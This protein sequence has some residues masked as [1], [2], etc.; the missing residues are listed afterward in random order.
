M[1]QRFRLNIA[2]WR[3][4]P[5]FLL[6]AGVALLL[7]AN[8]VAAAFA[9]EPWGA[10][11]EDLERQAAALRQQI[12]QQRTTLDRTKAILKKVEV[13]RGESDQFVDKYLL[14]KSSLASSLAKELEQSARKS[15]IRQ[16]DTTFS[17]EPIEG[18]DT[19][20]KAVVT[21]TYEGTYADLILFL[22][23]L[24]RSDRLLI[25]EGLS[26]APQQ[27]GLTLGV[28][29]KLNSIVREGG[30]LPVEEP[31]SA[32]VVEAVPPPQPA[33]PRAAPAPIPAPAQPGPAA[34]P[35]LQPARGFA[36]GPPPRL[37]VGPLARPKREERPTQ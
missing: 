5:R 36:S 31:P 24:D 3:K 14:G 37:R 4:D 22:N 17:F 30:P 8:V 34:A 1:P 18:S 29:L 6:R 10:S 26:A 9:F 13:A 19:L 35:P 15:G 2:K 11:V 16:K 21:G 28:T 27:G 20:T 7:A 33:P 12:R 32:Q 25:V 23:Q